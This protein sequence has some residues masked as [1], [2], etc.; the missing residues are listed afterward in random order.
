MVAYV[1]SAKVSV[2]PAQAGTSHPL[3]PAHGDDG[4]CNEMQ[5][6]ATEIKVSHAWPLVMRPTK[7]NEAT[8]ARAHECKQTER[9]HT[10]PNAGLATGS[11]SGQIGPGYGGPPLLVTPEQPRAPEVR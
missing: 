1:I 11:E 4:K 5:P 2:V 6:N 9:G 8:L 3:R 7:A 10:G